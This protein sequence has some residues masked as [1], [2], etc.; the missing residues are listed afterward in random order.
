MKAL[1]MNAIMA[2]TATLA[3]F[4]VTPAVAQQRP[5]SDPVLAAPNPEALFTSKDAKLNK[6]KQAAL[7]I[8]KELLQC[9]Q[10]SR[11]GEWLPSAE[12]RQAVADLMVPEYELGK[13]ASWIAAPKTGI[14]DQPVGVGLLKT[15]GAELVEVHGQFDTHG[16]LNPQTHRGVLDA[17]E[18]N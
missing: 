12:D 5:L 15:L 1:P 2:A 14:N 18:F 13:F 3:M 7:H 8:M 10:W 11:A 17:V 4:A 9:H 6:N 16:L